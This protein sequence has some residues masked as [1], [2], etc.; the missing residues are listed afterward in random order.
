MPFNAENMIR[1]VV[2]SPNDTLTF[3]IPDTYADKEPEKQK[4]VQNIIS[5]KTTIVSTLFLYS[6]DLQY[7]QIIKNKL[8]I[9]NPFL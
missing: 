2:K 1:T 9:V 8:K 3:S 5:E 7:N 6:E 4:T